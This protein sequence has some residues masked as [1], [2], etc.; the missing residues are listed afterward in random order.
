MIRRFLSFM[1]LVPLTFFLFSTFGLASE[2]V[3][4]LSLALE[5]LNFE[6][7]QGYDRVKMPDG[8]FS[9]E[10]GTPMLP[11]R[12]VQLAIPADLQVQSV[13]ITSFE[14]RELPGTYHICPG[15]PFYPVSDLPTKKEN[16]KFVE[17]DASVYGM[18]SEYPGKLAEVTNNGFLGGQHIAGVALYPLQYVPAEGRLILY[19]R[20][21]FKLVFRSASHSPAPVNRRSAKAVRF[22]SDLAKSMVIN[23]EDVRLD[24][25]GFLPGD[26]EIDYLII[27]DASFIPA[28]QELAEWKT[29]RGISTQIKDLSWVLSNYAGYDDPEKI[30]NCIRDYYANHETKWVLLGGDTPIMPHRLAPVMYTDIPCDF[31]FCD[32]DGNWDANG[33][34]VYG[35]YE[36]EV[37][38]Y[39]DVFVGRAP[40][41][42]LSQAQTFVSKCL[43]YETDPPTDYQTKILYAAEVLWPGTDAAVLKNYIDSS[44]VPDHFQATKLYETSGNLNRENFRDGLNEGQSIINHNGHGNYDV[45]SI[46]AEAWYSSDM[47]ALVNAPRH[48]LFYTFG[49]ITAAIDMDCI[50]EHFVNNPDGGGFAYCGNTRYGWG[51]PGAPL[52]GPGPEFDIEF[53]RALFDSADYQVGRTLGSSKIPFI[54]IAQDPTGD[55]PYYRW[56]MYTLLLLGDPTTELWTDTPGQLSVSH[57]PVFFAGMSYFDVNVAQESALVACVKD[58][59]ILGTA[60]SMGGSATVLFDGP[61]LTMGTMHVTVTKHDYM[62]YQD[63]VLVIPPEGPYVMYWSHEINDSQGNNNGV[64]N[65][66]ETIL[67]PITVKNIGVDDALNV[68]ATLRTDDSWIVVTDSV[69]NFGDIDSGMTAVSLGDYVFQTDAVCPD[70]HL[71]RF[72]LEAT[73]GETSWVTSFFQMVVEPDFIMSVIP[74]TVIVRQGDS[75]ST[76][77]IVT[78]LGGF[79]WPVDLTHST[80]PSGVTGHL[81]PDQLVPTDSSVF[82]VYAEPDA[83]PGIYPITITAAG[84]GIVREKEALFGVAPPPYYGPMWYVSTSGHDLV[85]NGSQEFPFRT[86]QKGIDAAADG[87]TILAE[88]GRYVEN[89]DF[90]GKA[91]LVTSR[92]IFDRMESTIDSTIIDGDSLAATVTFRS[93]EGPNSIIQGFTV[94]R[95]Y[96]VHGGGIRCYSSSPTVMHN[97]V[98]EN[99]CAEGYGGPGIYCEYG[100]N[101][102]IYRNLVAR[103]IGP[104]AIGVREY[105][106]PEVV[107]N[108]VCDNT[109]GG[110]SIIAGSHP[111]VRNNIFGNNVAYGIHVEAA[112]CDVSYNDVFGQDEDYAGDIG[113]Q[114]GINGNIS[115][116]PLF[117]NPPAGDYHLAV[118]SPCIDTGDPADSVP[119]GGGDRIDMG[120]LEHILEGPCLVYHS[121]QIDDSGGNNNGVVN[122]GEAVSTSITVRNSG[123]E[124]AYGVTGTLRE[125]DD[126]VVVTDSVKSFGDIDPGMTAVGIGDYLFEVSPSCP[127]SHRIDFFLELSDGSA[128]WISHFVQLVV[129]MDFTITAVPCTAFINAGDSTHFT[130]ILI[131]LG[132]FDAPVELSHSELPPEISG[133]IEPAQLVP[134]DSAI[135]RLYTTPEVAAGYHH[136]TIAAVGGEIT[137]EQEVILAVAPPPYQGPVWCV[138][139][140]GDDEFGNGSQEFPFRTIQKGIDSATG[141]DTVLVEKGRYVEN[142][143]F[144]GKALLLAS[145]FI[146]DGMT[147]TIESTVIDG[148]SSGTVVEF[149]SGE[150]FGSVIRGFTVTGGYAVYGGGILCHNSSPT[151]TENFVVENACMQGYG[152]PAIYCESGSNARLYRNVVARCVG[153]GAI[154]V[155][156]GS[157]PQVINNTICDNSWGGISIITGSDPYIK[158]NIFCNNVSY[159]VHV[160]SASCDVSYNDVFGHAENYV[161]I[162]DQTDINGNISADPLFENPSAGD[163]HLT[164]GSPCID[165]GD[166][167][168]I[169]M[170]AFEFMEFVR[171]DANDDGE[172][173]I[174]DAIFLLNYLFKQGS[175]PYPLDAGDANSDSEV[176]LADVVYLLNYLFGDGPPP[177]EG[178]PGPRNMFALRAAEGPSVSLWLEKR[179]CGGSGRIAET[180]VKGTFGVNLAGLQL[181]LKYSTQALDPELELPAHLKALQI[182]SGRSDGLLEVGALDLQGK[183]RISAG[184]S[185]ELLVLKARSR[186]LA[187]V[188]ITKAILVDG[189]GFVVPV[190][191]LAD[192][193]IEVVSRP[194][195]FSVSQNFPNPFNPQTQISYALPQDC[196]VKLTIYNLLGQRVRI[197]V[198]E[199][200]MAGYKKIFWDGKDEQGKDAAS[201]VYFYRV[202]AKDFDQTRKMLMLK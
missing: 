41:N 116:D 46:G 179:K 171:G 65:P 100:S 126:F 156:D 61:L 42:D 87:D 144:C 103:C 39:P 97:L 198:D 191:I 5:D 92:F 193:E 125:E 131:S 124:T 189:R 200:Q 180:A 8:R 127:D 64:A 32:L 27:T 75:D 192:E 98:V 122:P 81:D 6:K 73:N 130:L 154:G 188:R 54:P 89:I 38:M 102:R 186:D 114:T 184:S 111:Y 163:Y 19:T 91:V 199:H 178:V 71:V 88:K 202:Q 43:T 74:D 67:M 201:G 142:V 104:A 123:T 146:F 34:H 14:R 149:T 15:Q 78:S 80:L 109:W 107:N 174:E 2:T 157:N 120:A 76:E 77:V 160:A 95:G 84:D 176:D 139:P 22:Y 69:N 106:N 21:E 83:S 133:Q 70:S 94:T 128:S 51:M 24:T 59:Q 63:T 121:H 185:V 137:H 82:R 35:E 115:A 196:D 169:D 90:S 161:G 60:Y 113:D 105:S 148:D 4:E 37:D 110:I 28:F 158:N 119:P 58:G 29:L 13:E 175:A 147:A 166:P 85:G 48:S 12:F 9:A 159:G 145:H 7:V 129:E 18:P 26:E 56:T 96:A 181:A 45:I 1:G 132:G 112:S 173:T 36:D 167:H 152:G 177:A 182:Y 141:G 62:P 11:A 195:S 44:F 72:D 197:L 172:I 150:S 170:G 183:E 20:I 16:I 47:D 53:F 10:P 66:D 155:R 194:E 86:I 68:S 30:R 151:I 108:T 134:T 55:G 101:A 52:V 25:K 57:A 31:Y 40:S 23:P 117:V 93:G 140:S 187:D 153:P 118:G 138:S 49:C 162:P 50:A 135:F 3:F 17:P 165:A 190:K 99:W 168:L 136:I 79:I 164:A 33:N 143:N